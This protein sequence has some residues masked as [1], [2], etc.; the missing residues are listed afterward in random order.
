MVFDAR[1]AQKSVIP[2]KIPDSKMSI[3][4]T[5]NFCSV[6][7]LLKPNLSRAQGI[8]AMAYAINFARWHEENSL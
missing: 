5:L 4:W 6:E 8:W 7:Q 1:R 2:I 3:F